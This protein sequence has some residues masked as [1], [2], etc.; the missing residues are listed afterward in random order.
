MLTTYVFFP[1]PD[2]SQSEVGVDP[3][4]MTFPTDNVTFK[5]IRAAYQHMFVIPFIRDIET[6]QLAIMRAHEVEL[7]LAENAFF[8]VACLPKPARKD[9]SPRNAL[10]DELNSH[11]RKYGLTRG[12]FETEQL[13]KDIERQAIEQA[14]IYSIEPPH[15]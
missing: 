4:R 2:D 1:M 10:V 15:R 7:Q 14:R 3:R 5:G 11:Y 8:S 13:V 6:F 9:N 12:S